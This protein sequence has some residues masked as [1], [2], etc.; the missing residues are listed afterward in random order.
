MN[1]FVSFVVV[2]SVVTP[3]FADENIYFGANNYCLYD[4]NQDKCF[5]CAA[6]TSRAPG[7]CV[8]G[9]AGCMSASEIV[10]LSGRV[11]PEGGTGIY[12]YSCTSDGWVQV[13]MS[14]NCDYGEYYH[15]NA[16]TCVKCPSLTNIDG[17]EIAGLTNFVNQRPSIT[18]CFMPPLMEFED[19]RGIFVFKEECYYSEF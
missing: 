18:A 7:N 15:P 12:G 16:Y 5:W 11:T 19:E 10:Q 17:E 4:N 1:R 13:R 9:Y 14:S 8:K 2:M 3:L 6:E